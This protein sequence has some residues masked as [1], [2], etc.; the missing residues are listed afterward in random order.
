[1]GKLLSKSD[2]LKASDLVFEDVEVS[3]WGGV[4]RVVAM[5]GT[6]RDRWEAELVEVRNGKRVLKQKNVRASL[7]ARS[8][9]G[10]DGKRLF[11]DEEI[12]ELGRKSAAGLAVVFRVAQRLSGV[13]EDEMGELEKN[14]K[15]A[16]GDDS[17]SG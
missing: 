6:E 14:S 13:S 7:V 15:A 12:G 4:V 9:V 16:P 10:E 17:S 2:I 5:S 3:Q 11:T 1:M 8:I